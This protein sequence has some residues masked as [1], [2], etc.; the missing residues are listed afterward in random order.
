MIINDAIA[1][2]ER[3]FPYSELLKL[4][5]FKKYRDHYYDM[6]NN[7]YQR[8]PRNYYNLLLY[9][10]EI[11]AYNEQHA[12]GF[13]KRLKTESKD[14][15]NGEAIFSEIIVYRYY[16]RPTYEGLIKGINKINNECDIIIELLDGTKH[17]LEVFCVMPN[18][19][20][21]SNNEEIIVNDVKTHTQTEIASIRQKLLRKIGKQKQLTKPRN[22]F[23]V[24]E[25]NDPLI[26]G[27]FAILSSLSDG[28]KITINKETME[29]TSEG[30]DW[31]RSV[32]HDESTKFLKGIIY[33]SLGNYESRKFIFNPLFQKCANTEQM[34]S[35]DR[36]SAALLGGN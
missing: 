23:A 1:N 31:T 17:Y 25:L 11:H 12:R 16:I 22:N 7:G 32:F 35:I 8:E 5:F 27:D 19:R 9:L 4:D 14:W 34:G 28:Y 18:F 6:Q 20:M 21:P 15:K 26:A 2:L 13:V 33:F 3:Q 24:I 30:Y 29:K 36:Q 10:S